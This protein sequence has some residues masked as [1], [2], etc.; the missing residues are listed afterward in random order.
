MGRPMAAIQSK[1]DRQTPEVM[2]NLIHGLLRSGS[3]IDLNDLDPRQMRPER[4]LHRNAEK[5]YLDERSIPLV[6]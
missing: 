5:Y 1:E 3:E 4:N 6:I 2:T